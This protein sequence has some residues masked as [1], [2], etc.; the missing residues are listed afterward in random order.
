MC[1]DDEL[2]SRTDTKLGGWLCSEG[3][4][5]LVGD[6][7]SSSPSS[8]HSKSVLSLFRLVLTRT[9]CLLVDFLGSS[10]GASVET[11]CTQSCLLFLSLRT[12][13]LEF[14]RFDLSLGASSCDAIEVLFEFVNYRTVRTLLETRRQRVLL[15][16]IV[17]L[18]GSSGSLSSSGDSSGG[19]AACFL[20]KSEK[21]M[22]IIYIPS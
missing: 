16:S 18:T 4:L 9:R 2:F 17:L 11:L 15:T 19:L 7:S 13:S 8:M 6:W 5:A 20:W 10:F 12:K 1:G 14:L 3:D 21:L 22:S